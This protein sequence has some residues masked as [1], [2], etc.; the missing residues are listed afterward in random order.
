MKLLTEAFSV[1]NSM[2]LMEYSSDVTSQ[3]R[4]ISA[5]ASGW[6]THQ[7]IIVPDRTA[8]RSPSMRSF[9]SSVVMVYWIDRPRP[10]RMFLALYETSPGLSLA[11]A[12]TCRR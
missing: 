7:A 3:A 2:N 10:F 8:R 1:Q 6:A 11:T 4:L 5:W 12:G 9:A